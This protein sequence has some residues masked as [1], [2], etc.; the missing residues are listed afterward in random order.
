MFAAGVKPDWGARSPFVRGFVKEEEAM[1]LKRIALI[2]GVIF[3]IV[4]VLGWVPAFNPDGKLL[5]LFDVNPAHNLVHL[6]TGI[7][8]II[9]GMS[10]DKA[11]KTLFQV[12]GVIY[13]VAPHALRAWVPSRGLGRQMLRERAAIEAVVA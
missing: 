7:V 5:G 12:F 10:S 1:S 6:A 2:F 9:A 3:V 8:G 4:G 11:S 13:A